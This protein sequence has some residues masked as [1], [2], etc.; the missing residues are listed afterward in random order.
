MKP[1]TEALPCD[2]MEVESAYLFSVFLPE[3][4]DRLTD[5]LRNNLPHW[6]YSTLQSS[7]FLLFHMHIFWGPE[8]LSFTHFYARS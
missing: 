4:H 3:L 6:G 7:A 1:K 5:Y 2:R 8:T